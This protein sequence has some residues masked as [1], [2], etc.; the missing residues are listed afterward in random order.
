[1]LVPFVATAVFVVLEY[2]VGTGMVSAVDAGTG[3][4]RGDVRV[5]SPTVAE[6]L[7]AALHAQAAAEEEAAWMQGRCDVDEQDKQWH[8]AAAASAAVLVTVV[9]ALGRSEVTKVWRQ[10]LP[11]VAA[12]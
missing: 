4:H 1:M 3:S 11:P 2:E 9:E 7:V 8:A 12:R 6:E 5:A 10:P